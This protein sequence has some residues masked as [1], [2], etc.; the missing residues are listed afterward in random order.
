MILLRIKYSTGNKK[1]IHLQSKF[2][3]GS[4]GREGNM[5]RTIIFMLLTVVTMLCIVPE[6]AQSQDWQDPNSFT[7]YW[8]YSQTP[9]NNKA[10]RGKKDTLPAVPLSG[11][12]DLSVI[13]TCTDTMK[14]TLYFDYKPIGRTTWTQGYVDSII[15][16]KDTVLEFTLRSSTLN[17]LATFAAALRMRIAHHATTPEG[18]PSDF[19]S[20]TTYTQ[21]WIWKP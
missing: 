13:I 15:S 1:T 12:R 9:A 20:T 16:V 2:S 7:L 3:P 6:S 18:T 10:Y 4:P 19:D 11:V 14:S 21:K 17:R 5:K 8:W